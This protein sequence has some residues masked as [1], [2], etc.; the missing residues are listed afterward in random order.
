M[1]RFTLYLGESA[2][3]ADVTDLLRS[4]VARV[5]ASKPGLALI[6]TTEAIAEQLRE[7]FHDWRITPEVTS[8]I[9]KPRPKLPPR[10]HKH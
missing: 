2:N 1:A 8:S 10:K 4:H 7:T 9:P 6:E 3:V 5:I